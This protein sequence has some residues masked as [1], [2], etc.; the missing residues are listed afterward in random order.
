MH[1]VGPLAS[2]LKPGEHTRAAKWSSR[3]LSVPALPCNLHRYYDE[4]VGPC[5]FLLP[6]ATDLPRFHS[7]DWPEA[8]FLEKGIGW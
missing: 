2:T 1:R 7:S 5:I 8:P 4:R 3:R 6:N